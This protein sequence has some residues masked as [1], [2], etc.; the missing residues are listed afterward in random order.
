M[1]TLYACF[2]ATDANATIEFL[3]KVGFTRSLVVPDQNDPSVVTHAQLKWRDD[4]GV[5]L[6]SVRHDGTPLDS[7][8]ATFA[9]YLV[10]PDDAAVD[11]AWE[12]CLAAGAQPS[13]PPRDEPHGGRSCEVRG[14][15]GITLNV[16]SYSGE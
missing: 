4:G 6:G 7:A 2:R 9:L 10:V 11:T 5:M 8:A 12:R 14:P 15:D 3:E 16:G 1:T 13:Q